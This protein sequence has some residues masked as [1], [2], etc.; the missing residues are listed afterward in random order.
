MSGPIKPSEVAQAKANDI[1]EEVYEAFNELI[2][3][4]WDGTE[5]DVL[6]ED[7]ATLALEKL[8]AA[9]KNVTCEQLYDNHW[10]DVEGAYRKAGWSVAFDKPAYCETYDAHFTFRKG[11]RR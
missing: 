7:A 4:N 10:M 9:G 3:R 8:K 6:Q 11:R 1:P 5:S 2:A